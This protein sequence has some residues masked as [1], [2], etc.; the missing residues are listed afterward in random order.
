MLRRRLPAAV[1][2]TLIVA[3][4]MTPIQSSLAADRQEWL[5]RADLVAALQVMSPEERVG[6]EPIFLSERYTVLAYER[7]TQSFDSETG[8]AL[9]QPKM[10]EV[11]EPVPAAP[12]GITNLTLS[13]S[14]AYDNEAP[15]CRWNAQGF[16][17]WT[18]QPPNGTAGKDQFAMAWAN[19]LALRSDYAWGKYNDIG[20]HSIPMNRADVTP[21]VGVNYDFSEYYYPVYYADYG[22]LAVTISHAA[23]RKYQDTNLVLKYFHT[24]Q[25]LDYSVSFSP[26]GPSIGISPTTAQSSTAVYKVFQN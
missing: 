13:L 22:W 24:W 18:G 7:I 17:D 8:E 2:T 10:G 14:I 25:N 21:N 12:T 19:G 26:S 23:P 9:G 1:A 5:S 16:F 6:R 20:R 11:G 15:C 4:A 3:G